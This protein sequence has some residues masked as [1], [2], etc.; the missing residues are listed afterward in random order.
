MTDEVVPLETSVSE[1]S[2]Y[3]PNFQYSSR[4][5]QEEI[6]VNYDVGTSG[7]LLTQ[8]RSSKKSNNQEL[9]NLAVNSAYS[10]SAYSTYSSNIQSSYKAPV[11][12][13]N[14]DGDIIIDPGGDPDPDTIIP[15]G[16][17]GYIFTILIFAYIFFVAYKRKWARSVNS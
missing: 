14:P 7:V 5:K 8:S 15:V 12:P 4:K 17:G 10:S 1:L 16:D 2:L 3:H 9:N 6:R 11:D 13:N